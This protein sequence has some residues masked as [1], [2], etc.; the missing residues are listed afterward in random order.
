MIDIPKILRENYYLEGEIDD[1]E[2][3]VLHNAWYPK[4]FLQILAACLRSSNDL[5]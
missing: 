1:K 5:T 4:F 2:L 3:E